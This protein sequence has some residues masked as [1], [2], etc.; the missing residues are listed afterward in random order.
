MGGGTFSGSGVDGLRGAKRAKPGA[1]GDSLDDPFGAGE[2]DS[3]E[4]AG[5]IRAKKKN[6]KGASGLDAVQDTGLGDE[7]EGDGKERKRKKKQEKIAKERT[8]P[9]AIR[10]KNTKHKDDFDYDHYE[11]LGEVENYD[12]EDLGPVFILGLE[13]DPD[14]I[15]EPDEHAEVEDQKGHLACHLSYTKVREHIY[16]HHPH[17]REEKAKFDWW[18]VDIGTLPF[19]SRWIKKAEWVTPCA[20]EIGLGPSLFLMTQRAFFW[21]FLFFAIINIPLFLFYVAG[22]GTES[23]GGNFVTMFGKMALGNIGTS[24]MTCASVNAGQNE[25]KFDLQC[26][27]GTMRQFFEFGL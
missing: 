26:Q 18:N 13:K 16:Q 2:G 17:Y 24:G 21:L 23:T 4:G 15:I 1:G 7:E 8:G 12:D 14:E 11:N 20:K 25:K 6:V 27:Y 19:L 5:K 9:D 22:N 10:F 3:Q